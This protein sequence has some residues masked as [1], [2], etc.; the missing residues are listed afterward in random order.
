MVNKIMIYF[1]LIY[2]WFKSFN[3]TFKDNLLIIEK[4]KKEKEKFKK[5]DDK[6]RNKIFKILTEIVK[7]IFVECGVNVGLYYV[8]NKKDN[9]DEQIQLFNKLVAFFEDKENEKVCSMSEYKNLNKKIYIL[10]N[11]L[12]N[13]IKSIK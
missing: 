13:Y 11:I 5:I 6:N 7:L 8:H 10:L 4:I 3:A 1:K 12:Y 2:Y 9:N